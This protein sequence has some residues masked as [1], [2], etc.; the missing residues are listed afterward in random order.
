LAALLVAVFAATGGF[1]ATG[2]GA[3]L[4]AVLATVLGAVLGAVLTAVLTAV[5]GATLVTVLEG[6]ALVGATFAFVS[7]FI[8]SLAVFTAGLVVAFLA[9]TDAVGVFLGATFLAAGCVDARVTFFT[10]AAFFAAF[11]TFGKAIG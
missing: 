5:F 7:D 8:L 4:T 11:A 9:T 3:V 6:A 10:T 1:L 2:L